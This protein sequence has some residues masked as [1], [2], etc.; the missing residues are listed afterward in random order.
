[1]NAVTF[2]ATAVAMP[3]ARSLFEGTYLTDAFNNYDVAPDGSRFLLKREVGPSSIRV[4][5][6]W[7]QRLGR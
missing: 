4:V 3:E 2:P 1:M 6:N 5:V 7:D